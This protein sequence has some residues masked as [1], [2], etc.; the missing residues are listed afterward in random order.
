MDE[1]EILTRFKA[2]TL[3]R[4]EA[5]RL[6]N[7]R[8]P[9]VS[10]P[11]PQ[12]ASPTVLPPAE[13]HLAADGGYAVVGLAGRYPMAPDLHAFWENLREGR[14]TSCGTP[15]GRPGGSVLRPGQRGHLLDKVAEFDPEFFGLTP[16]E[17]ALMDPQ[18]RLFLEIAW[19]ALEDAGC[20]GAGLDALTGP[21]GVPRAVGVF[22]G[23][24]SADYALLAAGSWGRG[25]REMP[26]GGHGAC[27]A[28]WPRCSG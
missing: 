10:V 19:E 8:A 25:Q 9:D 3:G 1:R 24:S 20:T 6:L 12:A 15:A 18:E 13:H 14:D 28:G 23:V 11:A 26:A 17:G 4:E 5:E 7:A 27:P 2:G 22:A 21:G 16:C